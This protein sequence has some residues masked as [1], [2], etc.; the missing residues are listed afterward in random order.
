MK[1]YGIGIIILLISFVMGT[2][3]TYISYNYLANPP[4]ASDEAA[5]FDELKTSGLVALI[6]SVIGIIG[7]LIFLVEFM[8]H[9]HG[10]SPPKVSAP[11]P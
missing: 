10:V 11:P 6:S 9:E 4:S 3:A 1:P 8:K 7:I 2:Y 5:R